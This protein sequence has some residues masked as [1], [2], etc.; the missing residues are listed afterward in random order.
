MFQH[1]WLPGA[2]RDMEITDF[3]FAVRE[4]ERIN[5]RHAEQ[6]NKD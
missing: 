4:T 3:V 6:M 5:T 2:L 1:H